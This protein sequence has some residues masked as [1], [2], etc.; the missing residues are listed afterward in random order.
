M[1]INSVIDELKRIYPGKKIVLNDQHNLTEIVCE[2][3]PA[4]RHP[5]YSVA[6]SVIDSTYPHL[7]HKTTETYEVL[8]GELELTVEGK[9]FHLKKGESFTIQPGE[10]HY[11]KGNETWVKVTSK[12][13]WTQED[14]IKKTT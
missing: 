12:P 2:T 1:N 10:L 14:Y 5:N 11:A 7:H 13:G 8:R 4:A 9:T 6:V 3:E